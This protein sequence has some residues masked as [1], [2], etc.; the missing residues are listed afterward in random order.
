MNAKR[1]TSESCPKRVFHVLHVTTRP[2]L[3]FATIVTPVSSI[4]AETATQGTRRLHCGAS[5]N[6]WFAAP[7]AKHDEQ[8]TSPMDAKETLLS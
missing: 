3:Y 6:G 5:G 7:D 1:K 8:K 4:G 2:V